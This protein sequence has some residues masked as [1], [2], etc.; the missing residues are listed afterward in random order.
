M[1]NGLTADDVRLLSAWAASAE[2]HPGTSGSTSDGS[3]EAAAADLQ[4]FLDV[5]DDDDRALAAADAPRRTRKKRRATYVRN[6][7]RALACLFGSI[8]CP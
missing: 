1:E 6:R 3:S 4:L 2:E 5:V 7:V 8:A